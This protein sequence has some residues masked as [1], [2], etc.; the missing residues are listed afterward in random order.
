MLLVQI[1]SNF[2]LSY[3]FPLNDFLGLEQYV[4]LHPVL[5]LL[6][7]ITSKNATFFLSATFTIFVRFKREFVATRGSLRSLP[8]AVLRQ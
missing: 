6:S 1:H 2:T 4:Q 8:S 3:Y 5:Q 7:H